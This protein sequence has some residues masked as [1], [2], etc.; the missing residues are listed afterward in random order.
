MTHRCSRGTSPPAHPF[1]SPCKFL[2]ARL[3][4][5]SVMER[6]PWNGACPLM[7]KDILTIGKR[8]PPVPHLLN[9]PPIRGHRQMARTSAS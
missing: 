2:R 3:A 8:R 1:R 4:L 7:I 6:G 5:S 9:C